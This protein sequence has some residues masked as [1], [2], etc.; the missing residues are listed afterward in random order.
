M[1]LAVWGAEVAA[2][3]APQ[4]ARAARSTAPVGQEVAEAE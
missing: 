1:E 2:V 3:H 4:R